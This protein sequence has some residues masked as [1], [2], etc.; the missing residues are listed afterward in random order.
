[1]PVSYTHLDVYKRQAFTLRRC[2]L[3]AQDDRDVGDAKLARGL[4]AQMPVDQFAVISDQTR[5]LE[6]E[7]TN[8][9]AHAVHARIVLARRY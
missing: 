9:A 6:T 7:F 2:P 8:T 5:N 4:E 1:M 3:V